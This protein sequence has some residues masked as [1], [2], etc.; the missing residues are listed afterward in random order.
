M[1]TQ[2]IKDYIQENKD[3]LFQILKQ[4]AKI[5][6][7]SLAEDRRVAFCK[8][9]LEKAGASQVL[10]DDA[11]NVIL[12]LNCDN[13]DALT[14]FVAHLDVV[15]PDLEELPYRE[16]GDILSCPGIGDDTASAVVLLLAAKF[17]IQQK[18]MPKNGILLVWNSG[19]EGLGNLYGTKQI[20][21]DYQGRIAQFLSFDSTIN[22]FASQCVG[23]HRY[24]VE[25]ETEGGHSFLAFGNNNAIAVLANIIQDIY[26]IQVPHIGDSVTTFNVG[27]ISGGTSINTIA[28]S[29]KLL[30]EYRS[31]NVECLRIMEEKFHQIFEKAQTE[32]I[33]VKVDKI[34]DRPC[35]SNDLDQSKVQELFRQCENIVTEVTGKP[36]NDHPSS[37][38]CNIPLSLGIPAL[39]LG[40]YEGAGAH[41]REEWISKSSLPVG[42][43]VA[44]RVISLFI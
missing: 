3:E 31:T 1:D 27:T 19:E 37:T 36:V 2:M 24:E 25:V 21:K 12:P 16:E 18:V 35:A 39:C 44:I 26:Q 41:T 23:S 30:C 34:G 20:F 7:P 43:E 42:L 13:S 15:F 5:P 14:V 17:F 38:D 6:A 40:C 33:R 4:L 29:A 11:K 8:D 32:K 10:V 9:Y 22:K 28:Q